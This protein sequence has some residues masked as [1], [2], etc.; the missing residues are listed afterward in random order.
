MPDYVR[1]GVNRFKIPGRERSVDL[2]A[3]ICAFYRR[4]LDHVLAGND[5]V[6]QFEEEWNEIRDRWMSERGRRD[7]GRITRA[8][9]MA[10]A[11]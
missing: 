9:S 1:L 8:Q 4:V 10:I 11:P 2:V 3:D 6:P 5:G 7:E